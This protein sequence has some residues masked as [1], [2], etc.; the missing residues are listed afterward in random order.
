M[1]KAK[2]E[3]ELLD[4]ELEEEDPPKDEG[5]F[6]G[7]LDGASHAPWWGISVVFHILVI[8][9]ISLITM[10]ISGIGDNNSI[11]ITTSLEKQPQ[12]EQLEK[13]KVDSK[14]ILESDHD[15][16]PTDPNATNAS[17][18]V[19]PPDILAINPRAP[20]ASRP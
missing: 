5:G 7:S 16:P 13:P 18:I 20:S 19:V 10:T 9:L 2:E 12:Y 3:E 11:V 14:N 1:A 6:F 8:M 17:D 15:T 4:E